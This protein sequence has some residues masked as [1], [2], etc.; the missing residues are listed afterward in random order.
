[1]SKAERAQKLR[2]LVHLLAEAAEVVIREWETEDDANSHYDPLLPSAKLYQARRTL[3]GTCGMCIDIVQEPQS[4]LMEMA[5][6]QYVARALHIAAEA[7]IADVLAA[8]DPKEGM[9]ITDIAKTVHVEERKLARVLRCLCTVHVFIEVKDLHFA[10]SVTS[11][12]LANNDP[13]CCWL[14]TNGQAIYTASDKLPAVLFNPVKSRSYSLEE[15]A[16]QEAFNTSYWEYLETDV[17]EPDAV[18]KRRQEREVFGLA[19]VGGGRVH[20]PPLYAA[21]DYPWGALGTATIVDVGGGVGGMSLDLARRFPELRF[22]LQDRRPTIAQA[23]ELWQREMPDAVM[24]GRIQMMAHD[25]FAP[26]PVANADVY[27]MRYVLHD[28]PDAEC[29]T[30]LTQ[31]RAA[32][33]RTSRILTADQAIHTTAGS[34]YLTR[35]PEPLPAN[36]GFAHVLANARDLNMMALFNGMERTPE[37]LGALAEKAGLR[38]VK[39]WECRGMVAITEMCRDDWDE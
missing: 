18:A 22:V 21:T 23:R 14:L 31:L 9:P 5:M 15:T 4:R 12:V 8:I 39:V 20:A 27:L 10:N 34:A 24:S 29:V 28:W 7:R 32:M 35:A 6:D 3:V 38:L 17:G 11:Q 26:Q 13:L 33:S 36:Y 19:M 37:Q 16:F 1:M 2:S 30:I 25:F